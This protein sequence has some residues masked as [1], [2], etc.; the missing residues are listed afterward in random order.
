MKLT[1][2]GSSSKG[3][4]YI[5]EGKS[6]TLL[7]EAGIRIS[8]VKQALD[9]DLKKVIGCFVTHKHNDH[10]GYIKDYLAAGIQVMALESVFKSKNLGLL[11]GKSIEPGRGYIIGNFR[12]YAFEVSHG[13]PCLGF[14]ID[15][16]ECGRI[17]FLTDTMNCKYT[18]TE[19]TQVMIECNY[20]DEVLDS[21]IIEGKIPAFMRQ[22]LLSTHM[23]LQTTKKVLSNQ[24]LSQVRNIVLLHLSDGNSDEQRF[25]REINESTHKTVTAANKGVRLNFDLTPF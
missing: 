2:L 10:S 20:C 15:H 9:F 4:C 21:N 11:G 25:V 7:I 17:L 24:D 19:L 12:V 14:V 3:N 18:F 22:R 6:E 5:L 16:Q 8:E 1:V 13:V 23:E